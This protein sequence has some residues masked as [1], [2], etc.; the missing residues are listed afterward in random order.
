MTPSLAVKTGHIDGR[1]V[2]SPLRHR[3]PPPPPSPILNNML[4]PRDCFAT[5]EPKKNP[6]S[7]QKPA[8]ILVRT[9]NNDIWQ[10]SDKY[11]TDIAAAKLFCHSQYVYEMNGTV[12]Q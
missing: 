3:N 8:I 2:L 11:T 4:L 6:L 9:E 12:T 1:R 5:Q 7:S 10:C